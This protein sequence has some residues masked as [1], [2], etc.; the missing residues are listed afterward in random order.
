MC[1]W[2]YYYYVVGGS[3]VV[4]VHDDDGRSLFLEGLMIISFHLDDV[5]VTK[6]KPSSCKMMTRLCCCFPHLDSVS[7]CE[8]V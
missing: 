4:V 7:L 6:A 5:A 3:V 2:R 8:E 1:C